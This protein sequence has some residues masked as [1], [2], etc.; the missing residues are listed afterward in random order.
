LDTSKA[1]TPEKNEP[2]QNMKFTLR[3]TF[4]GRNISN[5]RTLRA[6]LETEIKFLKLVRKSNG[7]NSY[8]PTKILCNGEPLTEVMLME[9]IEIGI[10][11]MSR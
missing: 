5:H 6:A 4:N 3:D 8:I 7:S 9:A 10:Q 11:L 1:S 2:N